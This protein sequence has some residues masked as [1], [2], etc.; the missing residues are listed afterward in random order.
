MK[1]K[2][3]LRAPQNLKNYPLSGGFFSNFV[4]LSKNLDFNYLMWNH[5]YQLFRPCVQKYKMGK[6]A[7]ASQ[8]FP[9]AFYMASLY[10]S[11]YSMLGAVCTIYGQP[12][13]T[14][15]PKW[16]P[17]VTGCPRWI[18]IITAF[19]TYFSWYVCYYL[20]VLPLILLYFFPQPFCQPRI[21]VFVF[22]VNKENNL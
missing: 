5:T 20:K 9:P 21:Y 1:P 13:L 14:I 10:S 3:I 4:A 11:P 6:F 8:K 15:S 22:Q 19:L 17:M 7:H 12:A 16:K 18:I 2:N